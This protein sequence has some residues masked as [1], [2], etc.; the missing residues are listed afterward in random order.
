MK[1]WKL[2]TGKIGGGSCEQSFFLMN[3]REVHSHRRWIFDD[4]MIF[5]NAIEEVYF[6]RMVCKY[7]YS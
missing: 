1:L 5:F 2:K 7:I 4:E 3:F 6:K